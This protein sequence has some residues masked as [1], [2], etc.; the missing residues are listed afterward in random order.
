MKKFLVGAVAALALMAAPNVASAYEGG[1]YFDNNVGGWEVLHLGDNDDGTHRRLSG[2]GEA[3]GRRGASYATMR[4]TLRGGGGGDVS[5]WVDS[6]CGDFVR[7]CV[8][9][10]AGRTNCSTYLDYGWH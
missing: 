2:T 10:A 3:C 9:N 4:S 1:W 7:V 8:Q 6:S 5:W